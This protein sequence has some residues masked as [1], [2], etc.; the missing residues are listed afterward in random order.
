MKN[1]GNFA[2]AHM[3][4]PSLCLARSIHAD[5]VSI[6]NNHI[7]TNQVLSSI[8]KEKGHAS[9]HALSCIMEETR[10]ISSGRLSSLRYT[11]ASD[12]QPHS[13]ELYRIWQAPW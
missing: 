11:S 1:I 10:V 7:W 4:V 8:C 12:H 13:S 5:I 3:I 9:Q 2:L 6:K